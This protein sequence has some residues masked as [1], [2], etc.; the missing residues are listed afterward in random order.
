MEV[1]AALIWVAG[2][3]PLSISE[4]CETFGGIRI[5]GLRLQRMM[6]THYG[7]KRPLPL[8]RQVHFKIQVNS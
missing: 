5:E 2:S 8:L 7:H 4:V 3:M 1:D 6:G